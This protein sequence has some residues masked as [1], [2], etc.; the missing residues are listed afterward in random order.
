MRNI[1]T[2]QFHWFFSG[3][4]GKKYLFFFVSL[5]GLYSVSVPPCQCQLNYG[6]SL[7]VLLIS[8]FIAFRDL[9]EKWMPKHHTEPKYLELE[10]GK[11]I[12]LTRTKWS[13]FPC[14]AKWF[15]GTHKKKYGTYINLYTYVST[16]QCSVSFELM[17]KTTNIKIECLKIKALTH[18]H[19]HRH[20]HTKSIVPRNFL[21]CVILNELWT[22]I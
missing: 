1:W 3:V 2:T 5:F 17:M 9:P 20:I 22:W 11:F 13:N 7:F 8:G 19:G 16:H 21:L 6:F 18:T 4:K 10:L 14:T 15:L 12:E